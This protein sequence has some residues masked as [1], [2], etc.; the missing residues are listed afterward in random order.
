MEY[1]KL[2]KIHINRTNNKFYYSVNV[3][4]RNNNPI[5]E[6]NT[7]NIPNGKYM[8]DGL[9]MTINGLLKKDKG[10]FKLRLE[11]DIVIIDITKSAF[12]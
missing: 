9:I 7:V 5:N 12:N 2:K 4:D 10:F 3:I 1:Q 6:K 11:D 8:F